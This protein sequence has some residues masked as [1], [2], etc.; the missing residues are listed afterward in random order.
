MKHFSGAPLYDKLLALATNIA[1][2][3]GQTL[4]L[5]TNINKFWWQKFLKHWAHDSNKPFK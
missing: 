3:L 5:I 1:H 2:G 4:K